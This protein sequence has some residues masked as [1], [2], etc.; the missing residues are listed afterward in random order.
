MLKY[1]KQFD[2]FLKEN[3]EIEY[4]VKLTNISLPNIASDDDYDFI[5]GFCGKGF[6]QSLDNKE[7][8]TH[9]CNACP[10]CPEIF[11]EIDDLNN[12]IKNF[13]EKKDNTEQN[14]GDF[15]HMEPQM[16][17]EDNDRHSHSGE[18]L[19]ECNDVKKLIGTVMKKQEIQLARI[20][21]DSKKEKENFISFEDYRANVKKLLWKSKLEMIGNTVDNRNEIK[22]IMMHWDQP[23]DEFLFLVNIYQDNLHQDKIDQ[24]QFGKL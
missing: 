1:N 16:I 17:P 4:D 3:P 18:F 13:H 14:G 8:K 11:I 23:M 15:N 19:K 24:L 10:Y 9:K 5:C 21:I 2:K 7:F 20:Q 12:H 6:F 22:D